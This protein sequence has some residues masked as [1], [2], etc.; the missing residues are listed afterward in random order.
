MKILFSSK[1]HKLH[2]D[3]LHYIFVIQK[4]TIMASNA[5][6]QNTPT[7]PSPVLSSPLLFF[8]LVAHKDKTV[9]MSFTKLETPSTEYLYRLRLITMLC[10]IP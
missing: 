6:L 10:L 4:I 5:S 7:G 1:G 8:E 3:F 9:L 2:S